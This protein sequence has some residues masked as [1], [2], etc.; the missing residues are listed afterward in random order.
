MHRF[1]IF[2]LLL[3]SGFIKGTS[4]AQPGAVDTAFDPGSGADDLI[5]QVVTLDSGKILVGGYF[6][7]FNGSP[8]RGIVRLNAAGSVDTSFDPGAGADDGLSAIAVQ[9][10][11]K[12]VIG[13]A[14][15]HFNGVARNRIARLT[16]DGQLDPSFNPGSAVAGTRSPAVLSLALQPD[17]KILLAGSFTNVGGVLVN[18]LARLES[19]G[20]LDS[21]FNAGFEEGDGKGLFSVRLL[22]NG[23]IFAGGLFSR[24]QGQNRG[25]LVRLN[26]NGTLDSSFNANLDDL[27]VVFSTAIQ[28]NQKLLAGGYYFSLVTTQLISLASFNSDG[29]FDSTFRK[30][31][32]PTHQINSVVVQNDGKVLVGGYFPSFAGTSR[33]GVMRLLTDG[34]IDPE[35][36]PGSGVSGGAHPGLLSIALQKDGGIVI[37]GDFTQVNGT[38]RSRIAQLIGRVP[39]PLSI[40]AQPADQNVCPGH[41]AAFSV[42][43]AGDGPITYQWR[44]NGNLLMQATNSTYAI[45]SATEADTGSYDVI[46][47]GDSGSITSS[48]AQLDLKTPTVITTQ[49]ISQTV[50]AGQTVVLTAAAKGSGLLTYQWRKAG[51]TIPGA[52]QENYSIRGITKDDAGAYEVIVSGECGDATSAQASLVVENPV[53][54]TLQPTSKAVCLGEKTGFAIS[55][56]G[57]ASGIQWRRGGV[58]LPGATNLTYAIPAISNVDTGIYDVV[59][60]GACGSVTSSAAALDLLSPA[61]ISTQPSSQTAGV[62]DDVAF[63]V[64][65]TGSNLRYSWRKDGQVLENVSGPALF[66]KS[67]GKANAG[68]YDVL[69]TSSCGNLTSEIAHLEVSDSF[70]LKAIGRVV[71]GGFAFNL[72]GIS[73]TA[74]SVEIS[75]DLRTWSPWTNVVV[76]ATGFLFI[77][78]SATNTPQSF[79]RAVL[80]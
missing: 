59:V 49:P 73:G 54:I 26:A 12:I 58:A 70:A 42:A 79:Y 41:R 28:S 69:I 60:Q 51:A 44:K 61:H 16:A 36:D 45:D 19:N 1:F 77:D 30:E 55:V 66:L 46:V 52:N 57:E 48:Q 15:T 10:D 78:W 68:A 23:Q 53:I 22:D 21:S 63:T 8:R 17:G 65:A 24:I 18:H 6:T 33:R 75:K 11:G 3:S 71:A 7:V 74:Y 76:G 38:S 56:S 31:S 20:Q 40:K 29:S 80:P 39:A 50:C 35:F 13:G 34:N 37:G 47:T 67:V 43:T 2:V 64:T 32:P 14:F 9:P 25:A 27:S 62:G 72:T 5:K 4:A